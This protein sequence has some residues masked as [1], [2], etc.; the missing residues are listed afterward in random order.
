MINHTYNNDL[1]T[2]EEKFWLSQLS[3]NLSMSS[4]THKNNNVDFEDRKRKLFTYRLPGQISREIL[5][6]SDQS[7]YGLFIILMSGV[8]YLLSIYTDNGD[9]SIGTPV[10]QSK[11]GAAYQ[12]HQLIIRSD[13]HSGMSFKELLFKVQQNISDANKNQKVSHDKLAKLLGFDSKTSN[14]LNPL[15]VVQLENIQRSSSNYDSYADTVFNFT[16]HGSTIECSITCNGI[17]GEM[18]G[19]I[20]DQLTHFFRAVV[21]NPNIRLS[22]IDILSNDRNQILYEFNNTAADFPRDKSVV[23]LFELQVSKTPHETAVVYQGQKLTYQELNKKANHIANE[24][25]KLGI[26]ENCVVGSMVDRSLELPIGVLGILKA[27]AAYLPIDPNYPIERIK[28]VIG[29]SNVD[30]ILKCSDHKHVYINQ[31]TLFIDIDTTLEKG[32]PVSMEKNLELEISSE[33]LMYVLYT[34]GSTGDPKGVMV[35]RNSFVNLL[36]WY[37]NEFDINEASNL[38]LIAPISFD[39][40]HKN[41]FA[42]LI[43]GGR[44]HLFEPGMYDY[45]KM[46]DYIEFHKITTINCT[47]S[48]FYPLVDYNEESDYSR[49]TSLKHVFLGGES[50]NCK[51]L[52]PLAESANFSS[53]IV[54]TYGPTECTDIAS[55]YRISNQELVQQK[56]IPIGKPLNNV[57]LYIVNQEMNLLPIGITGELCIAGVGLSQG[58]YNAPVLTKE[59]FVEFP[60]IPG[61]KVYKTG[62]MARWMPDGNIEFIGRIDNLTKIRGFR[63]EVGEIENCLLK[64]QDVE[65]AVVVA[66]E[67]T[68]GTKELSAYF[69]ANVDITNSELRNYLIKRVPD[70]MVPA[71]FTQLNKMP[72]NQNG[73]IDRKALPVPDLDNASSSSYVAPESELERMIAGIWEEVLNIERIGVYDNFFEL[74]GHS[75][76][77]ASIVLKINQVFETNLQISE[78]FKQPT[79]KEVVNLITKMQQHKRSTVLAVKE[80]EYYPVSSQQKRLFIMWQLNRDS[81][82][83]NL[84]SAIIIEGNLNPDKL[85]AV[86]QKLVDRHESL[87]TSFSFVG[88]QLVQ[89]VHPRLDVIVDF[90]EAPKDRLMEF[91]KSLVKP[92]NLEKPPLFRVTVIKIGENKHLLLTDAHHIV[93]DGISMDIIM[94]EFSDYYSDKNLPQAKIQYRDYAVWQEVFFQTDDFKRKEEYWLDLFK[95]GIPV[96]ELNTDYPRRPLQNY[97]GDHVLVT[98]SHDLTSRLRRVAAENGTTLYMVLLSALNVLFF[99]YT[100]QEDITIGSPT[101]GRSRPGLEG[102]IGMF[103]NTVVMR[104][105]PCREKTFQ[106]FLNEVKNTTLNA[107][108][109]EEYP[110]EVLIDQLGVHRN[111]GRNPM[112]DIMFSLDSN[113]NFFKDTKELSFHKFPI[114]SNMTQFD[115]FIHAMETNNSIDLKFKF[116]TNVF[117][118]E[119]V[120]RMADHFMRLLDEITQSVNML[121]QD[122]QIMSELEKQTILSGFNNTDAEFSYHQMTVHEIFENQVKETIS[123]TAVVCNGITLSYSELDS[124]ANQLARILRT[125]GVQ[126]NNIIGIIAEPSLEMVIGVLGVLKAGGAFLPIDPGFPISRIEYLLKDSNCQLIL[127]QHHLKGKLTFEQEVVGLDDETICNEDDSTLENINQSDDLAYV[128]YTSGTTGNPKGVMIEHRNLVNQLGGLIENMQFDQEFHHLLLAKVSFD[129][130]VQQIFLPILSGGKL[131][132]PEEELAAEPRKLWSFI[133]QNK[134]NMLGAVPAH[135]K[136]LINSASTNQ[137]LRYVFVAGEV[138]TKNLYDELRRTVNA[139][140]I[141]NLYGPTETT[142]FSTLYV[143]NEKEEGSSL[144]IGKPLNNYRAYILDQDH[145]PVPLGATGELCIAGA[146][147]GRGYINNPDLTNERFVSDPF[148]PGK[149]MYKTG[150]L[151][152]WLQ[153]GNIEYIGRIDHQVKIK[154]VRVEPDEIKEHLLNHSSVKDAVVIA[155]QNQSDE[156]YL[157]AYLITIQDVNTADLR[158]YLK[159]KLPDYMIPSHFVKLESMPLTNS[160]KIDVRALQK[161]KDEDYMLSGPSYKAPGTQIE[162]TIADIWKQVLGVNKVGIHDHF[163]ELGG[164]SLNIVQ[165]N[166]RLKEELNIDLPVV[167]LFRHTTIYSLAQQLKLINAEPE[168][169]N[170]DRVQVMEE[171]RNRLKDRRRRKRDWNES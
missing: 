150:D 21:E 145:S 162:I 74:G 54:N 38:L 133:E 58:Y 79:I 123:K 128:I 118:K 135:L 53:E 160:D 127:T 165:V 35:K 103:V 19:K 125:K 69:V 5:K 96:L 154:G 132:I 110:F 94:E 117:M 36:Y 116:R 115:M 164:N 138:F 156:S 9:V 141:I 66:M 45:N 85:V 95:E 134:I 148:V 167:A 111:L 4:F 70:F 171:S 22:E 169:T 3:E 170:P 107:L 56:S 159:N 65:E 61:K 161:R 157:C 28:K 121:L 26:K 92:F 114:E 52:K 163:F 31:N 18:I 88:G 168:K 64:H 137:R 87:R 126:R 81:V 108:D 98:A 82:A 89:S 1:L 37:T 20:T 80:R 153:N 7:E 32:T 39:T 11:S 146:G 90:A 136:V 100:G 6:M 76:K 12:D 14:R 59:K 99:K 144:P 63:V 2:E 158:E 78:L 129:V 68:F 140:Q 10:I 139:D 122:I 106:K 84:P 41:L 43:R 15:T 40:A 86:F 77:A 67:D 60:H 46:S 29:N 24:L 149:R 47:P 25:V 102:V 112:F 91:V 152:R 124:K 8:K 119:T 166:E 27:G 16:W 33:S 113:E 44:L 62:D 109:H 42:P 120:L 97:E 34:S 75:L 155:K 55:F 13:I 17:A 57:E 131:Y 143:C 72:L 71:Y 83:Y 130:S 23:E 142:I 49:L 104:N 73:K 30:I 105:F 48:G 151:A 50:I 93:F 147:V 101:A 51:K